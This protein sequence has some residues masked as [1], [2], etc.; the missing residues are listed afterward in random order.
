ML[1]PSHDAIALRAA[2]I[3]R[4]RGYPAGQDLEIWLEAERQL[5]ADINAH[6]QRELFHETRSLRERVAREWGE[7]DTSPPRS[8]TSISLT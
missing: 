7:S 1:R 4:Q 8:P 6:S 3:W 5:F 2:E